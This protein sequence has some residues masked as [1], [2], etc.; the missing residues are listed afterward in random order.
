MMDWSTKLYNFE[1]GCCTMC[2]KVERMHVNNIFT[3]IATNNNFRQIEFL[4]TF[5]KPEKHTLVAE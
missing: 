3:K 5:D 1:A 2:D 4:K